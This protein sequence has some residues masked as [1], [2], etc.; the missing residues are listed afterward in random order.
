[1]NWIL[2]VVTF[3]AAGGQSSVATHKF[4]R[5]DTCVAV[6]HD[7]ERMLPNARVVCFKADVTASVA[8]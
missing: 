2:L 8:P 1:M 7:L 6:K 5:E 3:T 4:Y